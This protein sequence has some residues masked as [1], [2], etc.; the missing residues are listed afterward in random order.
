MNLYLRLLILYI[1]SFFKP[2][3]EGILGKSILRFRVLPTDLDLN[4]HM[5]NGRYA[6]IMDLGRL[7]LIMRNGLMKTMMRNRCLPVLGTLQLRFR[8]PL[9]PFQAYRLETRVLCWDDKWVYLEQQ[10]IIKAGPKAGAVAAIGL[11]KGGFYDSKNRRTVPTAELLAIM[12]VDAASPTFPDYITDWVQ[13]EE[14][15]RAVTQTQG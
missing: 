12:G 3:I 7:D 6:T 5:N 8:I 10:F 1:N 13:S 15:L 9:Q 11:I 2:P 14:S 4:A